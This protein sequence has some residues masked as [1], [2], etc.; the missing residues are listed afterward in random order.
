MCNQI[1]ALWRPN[2]DDE[3]DDFLIELAIASNAKIIIT[4]NIKDI[5]SAELQFDIEVLTPQQ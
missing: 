5:G 4:D 1:T 2:L 3:S